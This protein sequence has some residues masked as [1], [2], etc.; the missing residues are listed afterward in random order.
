MTRNDLKPCDAMQEE[1]Q[2]GASTQKLALVDDGAVDALCGYH[3]ARR[4]I[5]LDD[6]DDDEREIDAPNP[7]VAMF[8]GYLVVLCLFFLGHVL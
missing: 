4:A 7:W 3:A 1:H 8:L 6:R 2:Q 5:S